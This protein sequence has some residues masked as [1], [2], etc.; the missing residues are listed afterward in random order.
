MELATMP[1][2]VDDDGVERVVYAWRIAS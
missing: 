2:Y 1:L